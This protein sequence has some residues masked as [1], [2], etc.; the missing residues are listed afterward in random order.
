M[1]Q[2]RQPGTAPQACR[3]QRRNTKVQDMQPKECSATRKPQK[4]QGTSGQRPRG[5]AQR[6]AMQPQEQERGSKKD[7]RLQQ[8]AA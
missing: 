7:G 6:Q 4:A 8:V 5:A 1:E 2:A 3:V